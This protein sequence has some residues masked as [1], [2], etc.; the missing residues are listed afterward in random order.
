MDRTDNGFKNYEKLHSYIEKN[1]T[2]ATVKEQ[3]YDYNVK[4]SKAA[5]KV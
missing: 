1:Y 4:Y 5:Y 3:D 2:Q